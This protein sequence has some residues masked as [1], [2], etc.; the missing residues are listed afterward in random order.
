[1]Q[2]VLG[3]QDNLRYN[4]DIAGCI[5]LRKADA[6]TLPEFL[7]TIYKDCQYQRVQ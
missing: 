3:P 2:K 6:T 1:M 7:S 4:F 5:L